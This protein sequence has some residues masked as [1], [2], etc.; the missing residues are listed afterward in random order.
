MLTAIYLGTKLL[1][2]NRVAL[3]P[4]RTLSSHH[5]SQIPD[6]RQC[7][8]RGSPKICALTPHRHK[9]SDNVV[10]PL[11]FTDFAKPRHQLQFKRKKDYG[12]SLSFSALQLTKRRLQEDRKALINVDTSHTL[13][14]HHPLVHQ[15]P[16]LQHCL[17]FSPH[18][19]TIT[20]RDTMQ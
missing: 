4:C 7:T 3:P 5:C 12:D 14:G 19:L 13:A 1:I 6:S 10:A 9:S 11:P 17:L 15:A 16:Q 8:F 20:M 18:L 2:A